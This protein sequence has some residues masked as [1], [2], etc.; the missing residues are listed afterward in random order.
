MQESQERH[1]ACA[2]LPDALAAP[3]DARIMA[4]RSG[5]AAGGTDGMSAP[6]ARAFR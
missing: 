6:V 2:A 1:A 4:P 5:D 3:R